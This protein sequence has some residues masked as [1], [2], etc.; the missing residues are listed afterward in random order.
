MGPLD[1]YAD[2]LEQIHKEMEQ[3]GPFLEP[4]SPVLECLA[5]LTGEMKAAATR[6]MEELKGRFEAMAPGCT[7]RL[8][9]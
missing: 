9:S 3:A 2:R 5:S 1:A 4:S 8:T 6:T 7:T